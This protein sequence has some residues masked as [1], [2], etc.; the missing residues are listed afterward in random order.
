MIDQLLADRLRREKNICATCQR[1]LAVDSGR[2]WR[3]AWGLDMQQEIEDQKI[4]VVLSQHRGDFNNVLGIAAAISER[5]KWPIEVVDFRV[6]SNLF[7]GPMLM[8]LRAFPRSMSMARISV[9]LFLKGNKKQKIPTSASF[10]I[11]TLGAGETAN[12]CLSRATGAIGIHLGTPKRIPRRYFNYI[13]SHQGHAALPGEIDLPI[14]PS[15]LRLADFRSLRTR[16]TILLAIG[17]DT[18]E[19]CYGNDFWEILISR[20][21]ALALRKGLEWSLTTSPRTGQALEERI[22]LAL[23]RVAKEPK[24]V[25][26]YGS[27]SP[28]SMSTLLDDAGL[29]VATAESVSMISDGIASGA[30]VVAA[31]SGALPCSDRI[32][33]FLQKQVEEKRV[34]MWDVVVQEEPDTDG[35][36][37]LQK[38]WSD[39]LWTAISR[40]NFASV[41]AL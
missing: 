39:T 24:L 40:T 33:K 13:I 36:L 35:L 7:I 17:G 41:L 11:S 30:R 37:P 21:A 29:L 25:V 1:G 8:A 9:R 38:C 5:T 10:V 4:L 20:T 28:Q 34:A 31:Y 26:L 18:K 32:E 3:A 6:R 23:S 14:S 12:V 19:T 22:S 16:Q 15:R 27:G 2:R